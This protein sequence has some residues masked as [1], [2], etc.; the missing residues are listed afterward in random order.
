[1]CQQAKQFILDDDAAHQYFAYVGEFAAH[2][3][4]ALQTE[5]S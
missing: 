3:D 1:M 2:I 4:K 5:S